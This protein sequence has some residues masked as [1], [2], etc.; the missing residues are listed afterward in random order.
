MRSYSDCEEAGRE[1][2]KISSMER[3]MVVQ[4][5]EE[6]S[7]IVSMISRSPFILSM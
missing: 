2:R 7:K 6:T 5:Y 3:D 1:E 4:I